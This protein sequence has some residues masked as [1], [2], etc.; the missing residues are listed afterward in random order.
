MVSSAIEA[1][2]GLALIADPILVVRV[3]LGTDVS[4]GGLAL[5]RVAGFGLLAL[6][7]A[8]WPREN[9]VAAQAVYA[10]FTYNSLAAFYLGYLRVGVGFVGYLLV[11]ACALHAV[12]ALLLAGPA[13]ARFST[14]KQR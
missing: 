9:D 2:T 12:L 3:L 1:A 8:C 13:Y 11:P 4:G 10:L 7:L 14:A 6:G 5:G